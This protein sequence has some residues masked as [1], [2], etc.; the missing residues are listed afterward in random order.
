MNHCNVVWRGAWTRGK[1][2]TAEGTCPLGGPEENPEVCMSVS[3]TKTDLQGPEELEELEE[4][5]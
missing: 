5:V 2:G 1:G 3:S 4:C